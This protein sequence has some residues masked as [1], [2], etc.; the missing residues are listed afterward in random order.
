MIQQIQVNRIKRT[1]T[2]LVV[3]M[4]VSGVGNWGFV[5]FQF[6]SLTKLMERGFEEILVLFELVQTGFQ[7]KQ[8]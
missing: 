1:K 6:T 5:V 7:E 4:Q 3:C 8:R 2:A